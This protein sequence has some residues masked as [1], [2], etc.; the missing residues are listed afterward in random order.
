MPIS[1]LFW[2]LKNRPLQHRLVRIVTSENVDVV[3]LAEC[4]VTPAEILAALNSPGIEPAFAEPETF[5]PSPKLRLFTRLPVARFRP[6]LNGANGRTVVYRV[7]LTGR[8]PFLLALAHWPSKVNNDQQDQMLLAAE[9]VREIRQAE[10]DSGIERTV[11]VGDLN[12]NPYEPGMIGAAGLHAVM[13]RERAGRGERTVDGRTYPFFYN[14]MWAFFGD[15]TSG[16]AGTFH[17]DTGMVN[18]FWNIYDQVL[19]RPSLM[20]SLRELRI[21]ESDGQQS[22]LTRSGVPNVANASDHLPLL[23]RLEL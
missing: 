5:D 16:P 18:P 23:F 1:F 14:P 22:L 11:L 7:A 21:L 4:N 2:N 10:A 15:R 17:H 3:A 6:Q 13:T 8:L 9:F 12:M 20:N 19:L